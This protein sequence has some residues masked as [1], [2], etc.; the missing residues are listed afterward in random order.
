MISGLLK[1]APNPSSL[2]RNQLHYSSVTLFDYFR[3][4]H[5][6]HLGISIGHRSFFIDSA[7]V[8]KKGIRARNRGGHFFSTKGIGVFLVHSRNPCVNPLVSSRL[9]KH[10][11]RVLSKETRL[12]ARHEILRYAPGRHQRSRARS[13]CRLR[14]GNLIIEEA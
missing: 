6:A 12:L 13:G 4:T 10:L 11:L 1:R 5:T 3:G 9:T 7:C 14:R 2:S 8:K